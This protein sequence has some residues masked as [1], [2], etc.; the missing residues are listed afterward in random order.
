MKL[1]VVVTEDWFA[2]SHFIPLLSEL[3][4]IGDDVV[5]VTRSSG[6]FGEIEKLGVRTRA[7][8]MRRG[9][10]DIAGLRNVRDSLVRLIEDER[11][12]ATHSIAMQTMVMTS[13]ALAKA[14]H[15][16]S[17]VVMHLTGL[18]YLGHSRS[19]LASVLRPLA[20]GAI[21]RTMANRNAWLM[22]ENSDD[23]AKMVARGVVLPSRTAI[24]P[25]AGIDPAFF[26]ELAPP[27]NAV[28]QAAFVGRM[29]LSKGVDVLVE[30]HRQVLASGVKL[31]LALYG[32]ADP[33]SRQAV[34]Q[35]TLDQWNGQA[36][37]RWHGRTNDI[38]GVWRSADIAVVPSLA[39]EGMPRA[40]LEAAACGRPVVVSDIPGCRQFVRNGIEGF[41]VPPGDP[42]AMAR[43]LGRLATDSKLRLHMGAAARQRVLDGYTEETVRARIRALYQ[44]AMQPAGKSAA[45]ALH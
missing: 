6:R 44:A 27:A 14:R 3:A 28:P 5:V 33:G 15:R 24:V 16:P 39:G 8:D 41:V 31:E 36:G 1:M 40:M 32:A 10:L 38:L 21:R 30:A 18:G 25:G 11:P 19:P 2:L 4:K 42:E 7:F 17:A 34:P 23:V 13:L 37:I 20:Y 12:D 22:A 35:N 45:S 43:E 29:L 9:S 26:P